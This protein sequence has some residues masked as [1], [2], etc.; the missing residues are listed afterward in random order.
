MSEHFESRFAGRLE[1]MIEFKTALGYSRSTYFSQAVSFDKLCSLSFSAASVLTKEL[2]IQWANAQNP[3]FHGRACFIRG[4]GKYLVSVGE[5]AY[6]LPDKYTG[7]RTVFMPYIF[8]DRE[9]TGLFLEIDHFESKDPFQSYLLSVIFR[10]IYTCGL[11]PNE[12]RRLRRSSVNLLTGEILITETKMKKDRIVVMS[13]DMLRLADSYAKLRD[14]AFPDSEYFFPNK[15]GQPYSASWLQS[16]F[17][18]SF[19][20]SNA[21]IDPDALP[22]VRVYDLRHRF[23]SAALHR[24]LDEGKDLYS[25]LPYLRTYMGHRELSA[26]AYYIH[27]LPENLVRSAGIDWDALRNMIPE[28]ELWDE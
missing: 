15:N 18:D 10:L 2:V 4:F 1:D 20:A 19:A 24:W 26:T 21:D 7:G 3:G 6:I 27:L 28:V 11:R 17:K 22:P 16:K 5:E 13:D 8:T 23:A 14:T 12:G 25:R 9:L